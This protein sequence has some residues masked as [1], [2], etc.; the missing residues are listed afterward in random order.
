MM[1]GELEIEMGIGGSVKYL[2]ALVIS[3]ILSDGWRR[4]ARQMPHPST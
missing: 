3:L 1:G 4:A 2:M